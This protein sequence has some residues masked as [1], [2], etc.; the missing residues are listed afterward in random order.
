M[1]AQINDTCFHRKINFTIVGISGRGLFEPARMGLRPAFMNTACWR[2]YVAHYSILDGEL[3]LTSLEIALDDYPPLFGVSPTPA[4]YGG[5][6]YRGFQS[7]VSF[8]GS[9][10][11]ADGFIDELFETNETHPPWKYERVREVIFDGGRALEEYDRSAQ[12]ADVRAKFI[13]EMNRDRH[14]LEIAAWLRDF[15]RG[16]QM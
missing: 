16:P 12:M 1:T 10:L 11:L 15:W 4:T 13:D 2:G 3:F 7:P 5:Y 9:L 14:R 8:T 6:L